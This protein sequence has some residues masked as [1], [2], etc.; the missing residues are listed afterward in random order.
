MQGACGSCWTF[1]TTGCL[2]SAIAIA[3]GKL[4]SL[5]RDFLGLAEPFWEQDGERSAGPLTTGSTLGRVDFSAPRGFIFL[6]N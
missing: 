4:L 1:S 3:T 2:E 5:V 6:K